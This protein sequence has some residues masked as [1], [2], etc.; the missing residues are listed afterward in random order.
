MHDKSYI[1]L[2]R[3]LLK[4]AV[5]QMNAGLKRTGPA[6]FQTLDQVEGTVDLTAFR[7]RFAGSDK[8]L[9]VAFDEMTANLL[10]V[11]FEEASL[12]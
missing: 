1:C 5:D 8:D 11:V 2:V 6:M 3:D 12:R 4:S 7:Q 10:K 9:A